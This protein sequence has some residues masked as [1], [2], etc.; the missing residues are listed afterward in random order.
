MH[1]LP[2]Q[3]LLERYE[4]EDEVEQESRIQMMSFLRREP[5][6]FERFCEEGHF[7][8]SCWLVNAANSAVLLTHHRKLNMWLQLG[9]HADGDPDLL[10]VALREAAEESGLTAI[11][12]L[13]ENIFDLG[14]HTVPSMGSSPAHVHYDVRFLLRTED[15][16]PFTVSEESYDLR[17]LSRTAQDEQIPPNGDVRRMFKKWASAPVSL[18]DIGEKRRKCP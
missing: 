1:R 6:C 7:T 15:T 4:P 9:G 12:P 3:V 13:S 16:R 8:G 2:L 17:W 18:Q 11:H 5:A 14:V 10:R